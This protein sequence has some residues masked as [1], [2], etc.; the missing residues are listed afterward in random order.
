MDFMCDKEFIRVVDMIPDKE[1]RQ[2]LMSH[3]FEL[4][5]L[6]NKSNQR[7]E[8]LK[9]ETERLQKEVKYTENQYHELAGDN[10]KLKEELKMKFEDIVKS[11]RETSGLLDKRL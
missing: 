9:S 3:N 1:I 7:E 4:T 8:R 10:D 5:R 2:R 6:L 11:L